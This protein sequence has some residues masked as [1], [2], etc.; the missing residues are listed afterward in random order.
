M[1]KKI[2]ILDICVD[3]YS[4]RES[5]LR[6]DTF[7]S[8]TVLNIIE[9]VTMEKLVSAG[10][11]PVIKECLEQADLCI[12]GEREILSETGNDT[13]QR[14]REVC[15]QDFLRELLKRV[16]R[17]KKRVFLLAMTKAETE[18]MQETFREFVPRFAAAASCAIEECSSDMEAIVN[19]INGATPDVVI[20]GLPT[21]LE[22]EFIQMHKDKI[23]AGVWYGA[24]ICSY[25]KGR[26]RVGSTLRKLLLKGRLRHSVARYQNENKDRN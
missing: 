20:S 17:S 18:D 24:G 2:N 19:E 12:I 6:L 13:A 7:M 1:Y 10:E 3:N 16:V 11:Y 23:G 21:P 4:V 5:L 9:T 14:V 25:P 22:E 26:A 15:G 8:N